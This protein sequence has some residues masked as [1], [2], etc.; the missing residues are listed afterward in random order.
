MDSIELEASPRNILGKK[1]KTLRRAGLTPINVYGHGIASTALQVETRSLTRALAKAGK[2]TML[3]LAT[4]GQ[5]PRSVLVRN[6]QLDPPSHSLLHVDFYQV[7][8]TEKVK[9]EVPL[10]FVGQ[11]ATAVK[12]GV[13]IHLLTAIE[14]E[15]LPQDMPHVVEVDLSKLEGFDKPIHVKDL[16]LP[17]TVTVITNADEIVA[18]V[19]PPRVEEAIAEGAPAPT[20]AS[21]APPTEG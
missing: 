20:A 14:V 2:T 6:I 9:L 21:A 8:L 5:E 13:L 15:C 10:H 4:P 7:K 17:A 19:A 11:P 1:V 18:K 12:S 16:T 3:G